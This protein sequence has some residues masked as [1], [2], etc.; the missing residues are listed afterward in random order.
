MQ[1][2]V[3]VTTTGEKGVGVPAARRDHATILLE[4]S[5]KNIQLFITGGIDRNWHSLNDAWILKLDEGLRQ[6]SWYKVNNWSCIL[7]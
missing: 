2:W 5:P 1:S 3:R 4:G 7:M 6:G